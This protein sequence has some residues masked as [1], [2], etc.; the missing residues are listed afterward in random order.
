MPT[1]DLNAGGAAYVTLVV[2]AGQED[3]IEVNEEELDAEW[4]PVPNSTWLITTITL[5]RGMCMQIPN[6]T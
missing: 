5:E 1:S 3:A 4:L 6:I 2:P